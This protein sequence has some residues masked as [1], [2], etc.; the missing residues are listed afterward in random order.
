MYIHR[1]LLLAACIV[2]VFMPSIA[3]WL[4]GSD[5][6]WYRPYLLWLL[7]VIAVY[8]NQRSRYPDEL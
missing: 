1:A 7:L 6:V 3:Q 4:A 5:T 8:W 2:M